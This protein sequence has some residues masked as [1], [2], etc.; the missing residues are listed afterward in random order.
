MRKN[1][2]PNFPAPTHRATSRSRRQAGSIR[3][4]RRS[5]TPS[6]AVRSFFRMTVSQALGRR[7]KRGPSCSPS[8]SAY[9]SRAIPDPDSQGTFDVTGASG[10]DLSSLR[11]Q[12]AMSACRPGNDK[13]PVSI[14][15]KATSPRPGETLASI[16]VRPPDNSGVLRGLWAARPRTALAVRRGHPA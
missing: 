7:R 11:F 5:S 4:R 2:V 10:V 1:G 14:A 12:S 15:I 3:D 9:A 6:K 16:P 8:R 13:V